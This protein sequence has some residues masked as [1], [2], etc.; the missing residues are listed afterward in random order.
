M[1]RSTSIKN[2]ASIGGSNIVK[3]GLVLALDAANIKS[4]PGS[5][6]VWRDLSG[7]NISGSLVNG[8]TFSSANNGV[9]VFD[10]TN[11]YVDINNKYNFTSGSS[12]S[13]QLWIYFLN[14]SDRP[15]AAADIF[16]KGHFYANTWDIWLYNTHQI[17]FETRG[18]TTGITD[19][20]DTSALAINTW[21]NIAA[22]YNNT[23]KSIYVNGNIVGTSNYPGPGDFTNG[24]NVYIGSRQGDLSRSLRGRVSTTCLYT[25]SLSASEVLQNYN[26]QKSRFGL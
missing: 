13:A 21:H 14:H 4:Y 23:A 26:T 16:G 19:N 11:D 17:S 24:N 2:M 9:I 7:S 5:G 15:T 1:D 18:N 22:T 25:R 12:F 10:G 6:T 8:P 20:L 3:N